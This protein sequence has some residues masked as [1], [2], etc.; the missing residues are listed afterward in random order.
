MNKSLEQLKEE[1]YADWSTAD[2]AY[3]NAMVAA[4]DARSAA[5]EI[6]IAAAKV[7]RSADYENASDAWYD[8]D[9]AYNTKLE[10]AGDE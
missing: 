4:W 3:E 2:T 1:M 8:A 9:I 5:Y 6:A 10:E 7:A